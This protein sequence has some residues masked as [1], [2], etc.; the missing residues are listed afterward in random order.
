MIGGDWLGLHYVASSLLS[1]VL[2]TSFGYWLH[3]LWTFPGAVRGRTPFARYVLTMSANACDAASS[4]RILG[5]ISR[6]A[7]R[8]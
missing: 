5:A 2:V 1:F 8:F 7:S 4:W 6:S 3:T